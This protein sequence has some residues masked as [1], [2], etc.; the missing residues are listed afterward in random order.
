[1]EESLSS[2]SHSLAYS[3]TS[4]ENEQNYQKNPEFGKKK[5]KIKIPPKARFYFDALNVAG[6]E[7]TQSIGYSSA[8]VINDAWM[9]KNHQVFQSLIFVRQEYSKLWQAYSTIILF[10]LQYTRDFGK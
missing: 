7:S 4:Y 3:E 2:S 1:M 6:L 5:L 9:K 8:R 10:F